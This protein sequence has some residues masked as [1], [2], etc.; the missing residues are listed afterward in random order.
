M[1]ILYSFI[2]FCIGGLFGVG[3]T[4]LLVAADWEEKPS[5]RGNW[6]QDRDGRFEC[7]SCGWKWDKPGVWSSGCP[8]CM[9]KMS[10]PLSVSCAEVL[11]QV[12]KEA[13]HGSDA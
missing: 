8:H 5:G 13:E 4:A 12:D 2:A 7:S 9:A 1:H 3:I 11:R 10:V 6:L